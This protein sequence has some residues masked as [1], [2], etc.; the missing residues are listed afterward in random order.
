MK[1]PPIAVLGAGSWGT[2]LA[3]LLA[4]NQQTVHLW[5][6]NPSHIA[7]IQTTRYNAK[8][9]PDFLLSDNVLLFSDIAKALTEISDI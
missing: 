2:A 5:S 7:E 8:Y 1:H 4:K 3:L 6:H 9:L